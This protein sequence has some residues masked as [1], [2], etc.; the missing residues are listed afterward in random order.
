MLFILTSCNQVK[1]ESENINSLASKTNT[2]TGN[3]TPTPLTSKVEG[4]KRYALVIGNAKYEGDP[5]IGALTNPVNDARDMKNTLE[6][7]GFEVIYRENAGDRE[8]ME[9]AVEEFT[10]KLERDKGIGLFYYA[11]HGIQA[12]GENY[13]IPT[14]VSIPTQRELKYRAMSANYVL[15]KMEYAKNPMNII[16]LDACRN[17]PLP[18]GDGQTRGIA[19][20]GLAKMNNPRGSILVY[21][22]SPGT[23]AYDG[24]GRNGIFTKHLVKGIKEDAHLPIESML[25]RVRVRVREETKKYQVPQVPW[26]NTSL[27]SDFCFSPSGCKDPQAEAAERRAREAEIKA[28]EAE[29]KAKEA[30]KL[31]EIAEKRAREK[32]NISNNEMDKRNLEQAR[33][34]KKRAEEAEKRARE[35]ELRAQEA[36]RKA[37]EAAAQR[38]SNNGMNIPP[39]IAF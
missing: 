6:E 17:N 4:T 31:L 18:V 13:L 21:A 2:T 9:T 14:N 20:K 10:R 28:R 16:V 5:N 36:E 8:A 32:G 37:K 22:T 19:T 33:Q 24:N 25:K 15:D 1:D 27:E 38:N 3:F 23:G 12:N 11:G 30:Q 34:A 35:A 26:E 7:V 39:L 29:I